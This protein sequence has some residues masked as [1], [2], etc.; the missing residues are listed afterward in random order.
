MIQK[1]LGSIRLVSEQPGFKPEIGFIAPF[2]LLLRVHLHPLLA[3][4]ANCPFRPDW[5]GRWGAVLNIHHRLFVGSDKWAGIYLRKDSPSLDHPLSLHTHI[6]LFTG[7]SAA[8]VHENVLLCYEAPLKKETINTAWICFIK[9]CA[10]T[11]SYFAANLGHWPRAAR[12][13][14]L[15]LGKSP[16]KS[17]STSGRRN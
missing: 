17:S 4:L 13:E 9:R 12:R 3:L 1:E 10:T 11:F 7:D 15:H 14:E 6:Y 2:L 16:S 8:N 5:Q